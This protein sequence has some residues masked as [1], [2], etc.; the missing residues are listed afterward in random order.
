MKGEFLMKSL[1]KKLSLFFAGVVLL[2]CIILIG[3]TMVLFQQIETKMESVLYD[4]TLESYKTEVKS[5]VQSAVSVVSYYYDLS[6][7]GKMS[8]AD[9]QTE[10]L[11]T[12]R[13]L[14]Y[15]DDQSGYFWVDGTDYTLVMHPILPEQEGNNRYD[16]TD[17]NGVKIIQ[18]IMKSAENGGGFNEF[19]FTKSDGVTVAPKVAYSEP[20]NE[21]NWVITTGIYAD[22]IEGIVAAS[23]GIQEILSTFSN[24]GVLLIV[25]GVVLA[26]VMLIVSYIIILRLVQ[27]INKVKENLKSVSE[28]DLTTSLSSKYE[29]RK[30]ELGQMVAHTN[31]AIRTFHGSI[32][33][34]KE[35]ANI[36][37]N[38]SNQIKSMTESA[39]DATNQ[40]ART[41]ENVA[42]DATKQAG[43]ISD[44]VQHITNMS[45]DT[46]SMSVSLDNIG[47][48]TAR[49]SN[50]SNQMKE[51]MELMS[52]GS[53]VMTT[54]VSN[55]ADKI[56]ETNTSIQQMAAILDAIQEIAEQTNL[57]AL[58]ASIEAARAGEAGRG[59]AVVADSIKS[60]AENTTVELGNIKNIIDNLTTNFGE[61]SNYITEVVSSNQ[62]NVTYTDEVI[63][64]FEDVF[65]GISSTSEKVKSIS[66]LT[67][68]MSQLMKSIAEQIDNIQKSAESTA[69]AT[70]EVTA[71]SEELSALMS[72]VS[73]N[74]NTMTARSEN[75]VQDLSKF[76]VE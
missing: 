56:D 67:V 32:S 25:L 35:T 16:L 30:D 44:V 62:N 21:W 15:G 74:C 43:A 5:E 58:N 14:R 2:T 63:S 61:C 46:Q 8:E 73:D 1:A 75:L 3:T 76:K 38:N 53:T 19:Y 24:A 11:E 4:N 29:N 28:G 26:L 71:S 18:S 33:A 55:I 39:L 40:I 54:Q 69:A 6:Q 70:E 47:E 51:K 36:V 34:A 52:K 13:N 66:E 64:S 10:A 22:D 41:I 31:L 59:F 49:L 68:D 27:M 50:D 72:T 48:Y 60:L 57:L 20:F 12:L 45:E 37:S 42:A 7:S 9:A 65:D 23:D 17:K